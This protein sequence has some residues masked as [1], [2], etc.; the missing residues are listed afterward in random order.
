MV[1]VVGVWV[2]LKYQNLPCLKAVDS[3]A[4]TMPKLLEPPLRACQRSGYELFVALTMA[5]DGSTTCVELSVEALW[6]LS[7]RN[8]ITNLE[9]NDIV[10]DEPVA[11]R[12]ER[13]AT[14]VDLSAMFKID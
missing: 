7:G 1:V 14:C 6:N 11:W 3:N 9:T 10:A 13:N 2:G 4:V 5:P 12:E 8:R